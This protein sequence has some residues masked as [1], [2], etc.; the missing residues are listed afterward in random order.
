MI[1]IQRTLKDSGQDYRSF[2]I[3]NLGKYERQHYMSINQNLEDKDQ[4]KVLL[5]NHYP[6]CF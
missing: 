6:H 2:E 5:F 3:L 4:E 1:N